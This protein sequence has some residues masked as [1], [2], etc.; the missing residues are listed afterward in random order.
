MRAQAAHPYHAHRIGYRV[1]DL[2]NRKLDDPLAPWRWFELVDI[3]GKE[4][5]VFGVER[6]WGWRGSFLEQGLLMNFLRGLYTEKDDK[7]N[8]DAEDAN[9]PVST[10]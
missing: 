9:G 7:E 1:D 4:Y 6:S 2:R 10:E 5:R 3:H 8:A